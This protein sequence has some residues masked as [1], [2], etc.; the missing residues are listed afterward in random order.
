MSETPQEAFDR[1]HLAGSI[2][3]R[4]AEHEKHLSKINGSIDRFGTEMHAL[5]L[6]VQQLAAQAVSRDATA[7]TTAKAL[8]DADEARRAQAEQHWSPV[9]RILGAVAGL[10]ALIGIVLGIKVLSGR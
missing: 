2:A 5:T 6:A 4:L 3:E 9:Q 10:S 1:G 7:I 8:K